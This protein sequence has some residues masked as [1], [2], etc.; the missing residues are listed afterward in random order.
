MEPTLWNGSTLLLRLTLSENAKVTIPINEPM[1]GRMVGGK[2]KV[3][4]KKGARGSG[5]IEPAV[6]GGACRDTTQP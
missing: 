1:S 5:G 6:D 2:C 3:N 4:A